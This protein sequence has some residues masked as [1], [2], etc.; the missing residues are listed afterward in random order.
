MLGIGQF[1]QIAKV[2]VRTLRHYDDV[3]LFRPASVDRVTGYRSYAA[4]QLPALNRILVLKDLGFTLAEITRMIETG[5][6]KDELIGMLRLR[7]AEAERKA[8]AEQQ[9]LSRVA[10]RINLL[11]GDLDMTEIEAAVVVKELDPIRLAVAREAAEGFGVEFG[12]IFGRLYPAIFGALER[13]GIT[14]AGPTCGRYEERHDGQIDVIAGVTVAPDAMLPSDAGSSVDAVVI[15]DLVRVE[16][17]AT[18][19]HRGSMKTIT[20]SYAILDR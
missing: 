10:A 8:E 6:S 1:A 7:Q 4:S 13:A 3:G 2:S 12:P 17:A 11:T 16:R 9:R 20:D 18:L 15:Q 14:P 5:V 19:V